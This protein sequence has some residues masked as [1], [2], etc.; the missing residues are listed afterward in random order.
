MT[1]KHSIAINGVVY[2]IESVER[3]HKDGIP[4]LKIICRDS[5]GGNKPHKELLIL[6]NTALLIKA[7]LIFYTKI[8]QRFYANNKIDAYQTSVYSI[9][10]SR[11][12]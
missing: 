3:S 12:L 6:N 1:K 4:M 9:I 10:W 11:V 2:E 5:S 7:A 8:T